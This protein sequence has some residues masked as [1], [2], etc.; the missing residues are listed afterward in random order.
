MD[1][2]VGIRRREPATWLDAGRNWRRYHA[3]RA[4]I[5]QP[6]GQRTKACRGEGR[7]WNEGDF[8]RGILSATAIET[9]AISFR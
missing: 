3:V 4:T 5:R 8:D 7:A 2:D 6:C 9:L 1:A